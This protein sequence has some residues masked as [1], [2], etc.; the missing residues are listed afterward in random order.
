MQIFLSAI[1]EYYEQAETDYF[2]FLAAVTMNHH[3]LAARATH[4][5]IEEYDCQIEIEIEI[6]HNQV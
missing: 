3:N 6:N 5:G 2:Y 4:C 1:C